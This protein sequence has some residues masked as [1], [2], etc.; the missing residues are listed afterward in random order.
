MPSYRRLPS[1]KWQA[2]VYMPNGKRIT[3]TDPL[4]SVVKDWA[5]EVEAKFRRGSVRDPRAGRITLDEWHDRWWAARVVTDETAER[6]RRNLDR[7]VLPQWGSWPLEAITRMEVEGWVKRLAKDGGRTRDGDRKPLGAPTIHL[8]FMVLSSMLRAATLET[9]PVIEHNPCQGVRLPPLPPKRRR[10]FTDDEQAAI[11]GKLI[12]PY[13]TLAELSMWSG[14]RFEELAGLHG[15]GVDWIG[16]LILGVQWVMTPNGLRPYPKTD[17]S[18]NVIPVPPHVMDA[19]RERIR[20]RDLGGLVFV[21]RRGGPVNYKTFYWHWRRAC[22]AA[23]VRYA[24]PHTCRHT[25]ASRLMQSGVSIF[26]VQA[27]LRHRNIATTQ[28]YSH[29]DPGAH[30]GIKKAWTDRAKTEQRRDQ[31]G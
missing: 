2:T 26:D 18:D 7:L 13:R 21:N 11:L 9:P 29:H 25:A 4:K 23:K 16:G 14:L 3:K 20:G 6:D 31:N 27:M 8:A 24:P 5:G 10:Y 17:E 1:G 15:D 28:Q 30:A 22:E 12:E 19:M